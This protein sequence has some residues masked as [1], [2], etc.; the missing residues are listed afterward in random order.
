MSFKRF[1]I[2][3]VVVSAESISTPVWSGNQTTLTG[4]FTSST[5]V[6]GASGDYYYNVYQ[7]SA[8]L[9]A[10]RVQFSLAYGHKKGSGSLYFNPRVPAKTPSS[11]VYGQ[12]RSLILGDEDADFVFGGVSSEHF[13]AVSINRARYKEKLLPG[14]F[15]LTLAHSASNGQT[16]VKTLTDN[17]KVASTVTFTDAGRVY[18]LVSGSLGT[19]NT[20]L[21]NNGYTLAN[22]S[23]GKLLPDVGVILLNAKALN[24]SPVSGGLRLEANELANTFTYSGSKNNLQ[25]GYDLFDRGGSFR[26]QSEETI[27]S[28][29]VFVRAR[30]SEF[31]YSSNPSLITG[32]GELR[33]DVMIN[34]PQSYI[35]A[36]GL[37]NDNNDLLAVAKLSRPLLKDFTKEALVRVK[38][39]Y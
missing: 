17:S 27:A 16:Y 37:Y 8:S 30:N 6:G 11:T 19:V 9:D 14:T 7:T 2:E 33:H 15:T 38:L 20:S 4:F 39:D 18:E 5:Q 1:D 22:G 23:Y 28:N 36:V 24:S 34:S 32:S 29:F 25:Q 26:I 12:Y 13:Y 10:A 35:T 3:D 31:N 21:S